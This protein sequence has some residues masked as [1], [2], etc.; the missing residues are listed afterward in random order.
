MLFL[1]PF[2]QCPN[3]SSRMSPFWTFLCKQVCADIQ[4]ACI[5][6]HQN[7][8]THVHRLIQVKPS[9]V[10]MVMP[11][12]LQWVINSFTIIVLSR[13]SFIFC[14]KSLSSEKKA[15]IWGQSYRDCQRDTHIF[16]SNT[17][18]VYV[19]HHKMFIN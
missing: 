15:G 14:L 3:I 17:P 7:K 11:K 5:N 10:G 4:N 6:M 13:Q 8:S 12:K 1:T 2:K 9:V 16:S 18:F 19:C